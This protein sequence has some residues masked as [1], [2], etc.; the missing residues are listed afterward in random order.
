M[1]RERR[2]REGK[3]FY[4]PPFTGPANHNSNMEA[5]AEGRS[6]IRTGFP[7]YRGDWKSFEKNCLASLTPARCQRGSHCSNKGIQQAMAMAICNRPT[8]GSHLLITARSTAALVVFREDMQVGGIRC[9]VK[10]CTF[11]YRPR[12]VISNSSGLLVGR[13]CHRPLPQD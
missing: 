12:A 8:E 10:G 13:R 9:R 6:F 2:S 4:G 11:V 7:V 5:E 1:T 3:L